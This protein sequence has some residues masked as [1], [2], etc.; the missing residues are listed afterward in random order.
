MAMKYDRHSKAVLRSERWKAVRLQAKRRDGWKCVACGVTGRLEVD[1][2]IPVR[3]APERAFD[4]TNLQTLCVSCHSRKTRVEVG[5][6]E[7][8]PAREAWK[9]AVAAL[10]AKPSSKRGHHA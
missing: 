7:V 3:A 8:N 5:M 9:E 4:L 2:I 1:H 6:G 10:T